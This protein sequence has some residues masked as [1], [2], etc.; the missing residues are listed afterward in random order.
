MQTI[1]TEGNNPYLLLARNATGVVSRYIE[2]RRYKQDVVVEF[3][4]Y[5]SAVTR[6]VWTGYE[7]E[8]AV[9]PVCTRIAID[10]LVTNRE[11]IRAAIVW[12]D[13]GE[14]VLSDGEENE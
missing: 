6:N 10:P 9:V 2:I 14:W 12:H 8:D 4:T 5:D 7:W 13:T 3:A 11:L 1:W